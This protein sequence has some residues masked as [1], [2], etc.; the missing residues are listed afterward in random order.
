MAPVL[1]GLYHHPVVIMLSSLIRATEDVSEEISQIQETKEQQ[2]HGLTMT[3]AFRNLSRPDVRT[4]FLLITINMFL[5]TFSGDLAV[6]Y[7]SVNIFKNAGV[8][9]D[10]YLASIIV[11][12]IRVTGGVLG[13]FLIQRLPRV[14]LA[15]MSITLM[16]AS[17]AVLGG[18]LYVK[19]D[20]AYS[21]VLDVVP[22]I[23]LTFYMLCLG[24]A[25]GP[26]VWVFLGELLPREYKAV[27][28][29][30]CRGEV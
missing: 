2:D 22:L 21:T 29:T 19:R 28:S 3:E 4:S 8:S 12:A 24:A 20:S 15:M 6:I 16:S 18:V 11:A 14:R 23:S 7:Y 25:S 26:L 13:I 10:K 9:I 27:F 17:M 30:Q 5:V 1:Y